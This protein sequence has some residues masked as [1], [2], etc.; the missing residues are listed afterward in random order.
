MW[1][2]E[3]ILVGTDFSPSG[4]AAVEVAS[5][6]S[7][8]TGATIEIVHVIDPRPQARSRYEIVDDLLALRR[9]TAEAKR[10]ARLRLEELAKETGVSQARVSVLSGEPAATLLSK[11]AS[12]EPDLTVLGA[13][14]LRGLRR[15]VL[16]SLADRALRRPGGPLLL[17]NERPPAGE[18]KKILAAVELPDAPTL[19]LRDAL[20]IGHQLRSEVVILHVLPATGYVSDT[21]HVELA[22]ESAP[23]RLEKL[24]RG[25]DPTIPIEIS[26]R[27]GDPAAVIPAFAKRLGADLV[28]LGAER[29]DDGWPGRVADRV[30]RAALPALLYVW[31][32]PELRG[33]PD[34]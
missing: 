32:E 19:W 11:R 26:L 28:V 9:D 12:E 16:G 3:R 4:N 10:K 5:A 22:P 18:F 31:P 29:R 14:G 15:F 7:R 23:A 27:R 17:V 24:A 33:E 30:A 6:L 13:R 1:S 25:F 20:A 2:P 8:R 21:R 34:A